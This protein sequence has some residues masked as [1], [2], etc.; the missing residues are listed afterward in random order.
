[1]AEAIGVEVKGR[2]VQ[3]FRA[4]KKD[5]ARGKG[6]PMVVKVEDEETRTKILENAKKLKRTDRWKTVFVAHDLTF[7]QREEARKEETRLQEEATEKNGIGKKK[8]MGKTESI[9][10]LV[11]GVGDG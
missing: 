10:W 9:S 8:T 3:K 2:I 7:I 6:R 5:D 1:M 4:G 11:R